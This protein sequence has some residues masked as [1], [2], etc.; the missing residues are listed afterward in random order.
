MSLARICLLRS[1][2]VGF[3]PTSRGQKA[4]ARGGT[5]ALC[6]LAIYCYLT[7]WNSAVWPVRF[8]TNFTQSPAFTTPF[9]CQL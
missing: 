4:G 9:V 1:F 8:R 3:L 5:P 7:I 6:L 2:K